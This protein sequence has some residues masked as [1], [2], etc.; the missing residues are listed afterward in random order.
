M[1]GGPRK[2]V[3]EVQSRLSSEGFS[4][5]ETKG[6]DSVQGDAG[7]CDVGNE[8]CPTFR[9]Y[10]YILTGMTDGLGTDY[11]SEGDPILKTFL[12]MTPV[13]KVVTQG[14]LRSYHGTCVFHKSF[15]YNLLL[16]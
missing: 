5:E 12:S 1:R 9:K 6:L 4:S 7:D 14:D 16:A 11:R 8:T 13:R 3:W 15:V 2:D 10:W